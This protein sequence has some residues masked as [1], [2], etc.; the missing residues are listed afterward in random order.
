MPALREQA[1]RRLE[2]PEEPEDARRK[3]GSS[4]RTSEHRRCGWQAG[5]GYRPLTY[6]EAR[7]VSSA[8]TTPTT[9]ND[10]AEPGRRAPAG[11]LALLY[12][13]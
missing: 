5:T 12:A 3:R 10:G 9:S 2:V 6:S 11:R 1:N 4:F 7:A 13:V 8:H